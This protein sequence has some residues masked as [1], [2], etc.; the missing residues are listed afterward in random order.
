MCLRRSWV[1]RCSHEPKLE[2]ACKRASARACG[3][4]CL[5]LVT[6][7]HS[8]DMHRYANQASWRPSK[9]QAQPTHLL[10][11]TF[12]VEHLQARQPPHT[13]TTEYCPHCLSGGGVGATS[14]IVPTWPYPETVATSLRHGLCGDAAGSNQR[15][16][17][18]GEVLAT[19]VGQ[20]RNNPPTHMLHTC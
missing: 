12:N 14:A 6:H 19:F 20:A 3:R 18:N 15:Y 1:P 16:L 7:A 9:S 2:G 10:T 11:H 8:E 4:A 13:S 17:A 5:A